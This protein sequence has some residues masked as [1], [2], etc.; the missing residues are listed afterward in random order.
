MKQRLAA[1][2]LAIFLCVLPAICAQAQNSDTST[3]PEDHVIKVHREATVFAKPDLGILVMSIRSSAPISEE[4]VAANAEKAKAVEAALAGMGYAAQYKIGTVVFGDGGNAMMRPDPQGITVYEATQ[5]VYVFFEGTD[6]S[7]MTQLTKKSAAVI[8]AL[9]K[10]GAVPG[11][12]PGPRFMPQ[13]M[14]GGLIIYTVK[15]SEPY[16]REALKKAIARCRGA[17]E[18]IAAGL[19]LQIAGVK[20]VQSLFLSGTEMSA[21]Q[22][23]LEGL[24]YHYYST[25][26]GE[27]EITERATVDFESK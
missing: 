20:D 9:R 27:V 26:S 6:L 18:D 24:P 5:S 15:D 1:L 25:K 14:T 8:E 16:E 12:P 17:A 7:D 22:L 21:R 2:T 19:N 23:S 4:A 11:M 13:M 3:K 10:A